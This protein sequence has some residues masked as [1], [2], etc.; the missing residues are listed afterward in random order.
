MYGPDIFDPN[1]VYLVV[2]SKKFNISEKVGENRNVFVLCS[3]NIVTHR[4][5]LLFRS[6]SYATNFRKSVVRHT[7]HQLPCPAD[8]LLP[9]ILPKIES[10]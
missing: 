6:S 10:L 1:V 2:Q 8:W 4:F 3:A 9:E 5:I 7:D